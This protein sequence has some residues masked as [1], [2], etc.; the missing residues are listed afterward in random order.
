MSVSALAR[1][2]R[3]A[4]A[5]LVLATAGCRTMPPSELLGDW[6]SGASPQEIGKRVAENFVAR[7]LNYE[8][9][10]TRKYVIYPE[11]CAWYGAL[12]FARES[13]DSRLRD[14]LIHKFDPL[15]TPEGAKRISPDAHVD[16][17]VFGV[18]P[19]EIYLQTKERKYLELGRSFADK[20]WENPTDDGITREARYWIDDMFMITAVQVQAYRAA[21]DAAYLDRAATTMSAYLDKLQQ[22]NGLFYHAPDVP[23]FWSRGN[24][25]CA[26]GMT[27]LLRSLPGNHPQRARILSGY[28][29]MMTSLLKYQGEDGLWR[30]LLDHPES[31]P[32]TSGTGM[33][34]FALITGVK[35]GWLEPE[36]YGPA[37]R[38]GWLGLV[39]H[40][41]TNAEIGE[42]CEGTN[43]KNDLQ[44]YLDRKRNVGDYHGQAPVLWCATALLR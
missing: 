12:T 21:G 18:V 22:T 1:F 35:K 5:A 29:L 32:E 15:L 37:A 24:G 23:F 42:V 19:L 38:M 20:Q 30:Q 31:W 3:A 41:N 27:E 39:K 6:P 10:S 7:P 33:F 25:W 13:G 4:G 40:I 17:R 26:A 14:Q 9:N 28:R 2:V 43:K 8:T 36:A 34:T 11:V 44:Y 16:Y